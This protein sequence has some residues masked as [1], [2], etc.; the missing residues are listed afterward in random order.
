MG[1]PSLHVR[2]GHPPFLELNWERSVA[3]WDSGPLV[4]M[5]TGVHRH[6]VVF[7]SYPEGVYAIKELPVRYARREYEALLALEERGT[8]S[9]TV[10]GLVHRDWLDDHAEASA[11]VITRYVDYAFPYRELV[12]GEGFGARRINVRDA[13]ASL[14]VELHLAGC[15]WGDCSLSNAL[16]RYDAGSIDA[17]MIDAETSS[18][19]NSL[20]DGQREHDLEIMIENVS[21]AMADIAV[22]QGSTLDRAD[23]EFGVDTAAQY[24]VLWDELSSDLVITP[25]ESFRIRERIARLN[26]LGFSVDEVDMEPTGEGNLVRM[27]AK[28]GGRSFHSQRLRELTGVIA[29]ENQARAILSDINYYL[30]KVEHVES[31]SLKAVGVVKWRLDAFEP[32]MSEI[33]VLFDGDPIQGFCDLLQYRIGVASERGQDVPNAEALQL[34]IDAGMPGY[35]VEMAGGPDS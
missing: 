3:E 23:L 20:S 11:A 35:P 8:S 1:T 10:V 26:D 31:A 30:S 27:R 34:W 4:T 17:V 22:S 13:L 24:R 32:L 15:F 9:A 33:G 12:E 19:H 7:V 25:G 6:P 28:V 2:S 21:G 5:P 16:Y 14:L 29:S 18:L